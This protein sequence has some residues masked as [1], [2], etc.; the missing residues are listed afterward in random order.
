MAAIGVALWLNVLVALLR[1]YFELPWGYPLLAWSIRAIHPY[2]KSLPPCMCLTALG[3][4]AATMGEGEEEKSPWSLHPFEAELS[5]PQ[6]G[7]CPP[8]DI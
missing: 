2:E 6:K 8:W 3:L 4:T 7:P 5:E 1:W